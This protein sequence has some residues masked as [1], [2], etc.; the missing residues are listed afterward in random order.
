MQT[1]FRSVNL[2]L[3]P[4]HDE[5]LLDAIISMAQQKKTSM[6]ALIREILYKVLDVKKPSPA[7]S[8]EI[9]RAKQPT[10]RA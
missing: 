7:D 9:Q 6:A 1:K 3:H 10:L 4:I 2:N 5:V 8:L